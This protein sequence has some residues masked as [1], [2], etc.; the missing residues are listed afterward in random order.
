[1]STRA[2]ILTAAAVAFPPLFLAWAYFV[3]IPDPI[4]GT[5][6]DPAWNACVSQLVNNTGPNVPP[7][8]RDQTET[9]L[10]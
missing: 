3:A 8:L 7:C 9:R 5:N 1:M 2:V 6:T 4:Q 10:P